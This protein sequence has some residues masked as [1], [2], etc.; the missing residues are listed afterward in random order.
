MMSS[1]LPTHDCFLKKVVRE[2][3]FGGIDREHF[4]REEVY[5]GF[6]EMQCQ[7]HGYSELMARNI[8]AG[9]T[10]ADS[11]SQMFRNPGVKLDVAK[12]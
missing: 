11:E 1:N 10:I 7:F 5:V 6:L 12:A 9:T 3:D 4:R 8:R 2:I